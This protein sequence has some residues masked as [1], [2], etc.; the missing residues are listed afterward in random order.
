[1]YFNKEGLWRV[2]PRYSEVNGYWMCD[3]GRNVYKSTN[4]MTTEFVG[5]RDDHKKRAIKKENRLTQAIHKE[6]GNKVYKNSLDS[7]AQL[8]E[9]LGE[10]QS[11]A[12]VLTGQ[13]SC[14][15]YDAL[16]GFWK[17]QFGTNNVYHWAN[18]EDQWEA[19][20]GLLKRGDKNPNTKGLQ[21]ALQKH[22]ISAKKD[23]LQIKNSDFVMVAGPEN[24]WTYDDIPS[25]AQALADNKLV[26]WLSATHVEPAEQVGG[27]F[28]FLPVKTF[29]EKSG[30]FIN[31]EGREQK[32]SRI[33]IFVEQALTLSDVAAVLQGEF[34][35][36]E[37][38]NS[39]QRVH[40]EF[41]HERG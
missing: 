28:R 1:V 5:K 7:L 27:N 38:A 9:R 13:Y 31:Y 35:N 11:A 33:E 34:I 19:F 6:G 26:V 39:V 8:R 22:G 32:F 37:P 17:S 23:V 15:E 16:L 14:E 24:T 10:F 12:L 41:I 30:T 29:V 2:Q 18:N 21:Q 4:V 20:D 36:L 40:N 25:V 3:E